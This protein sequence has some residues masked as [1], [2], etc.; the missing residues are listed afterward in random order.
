MK[1]FSF[2]ILTLFL[3]AVNETA[4]QIPSITS[5][6]PAIAKAGTTVL[7]SGSG[8]S[9]NAQQNTV[10]FGP[11]RAEVTGSTATTIHVT[12]PYGCA[13]AFITVTV[14]A[15][16]AR[17]R[18]PFTLAF[19]GSD[20]FAFGSFAQRVEL[21]APGWLRQGTVADLD[22]DGRPDL[23]EPSNNNVVSVYRNISSPGSL[24][25]ASFAARLDFPVGTRPYN[26][27]RG[28]LDGDGK[29]DIICTNNS[30]ANITILRNIS[31]QGSVAFAR[32]DFPAMPTPQCAAVG[33]LD[34]DGK[35]D[36]A[37]TGSGQPGVLVLRNESTPGSVSLTTGIG[38]NTTI[39]CTGVAIADIDGDLK[40]DLVVARGCGVGE[41]SFLTV[42]R[43]TSTP[44]SFQFASGADFPCAIRPRPVAVADLDGDHK[45][46]V[47]FTAGTDAAA[48]VK[49]VSLFRNSSTI[50]SISFAT[51][52]DLDAG[53]SPWDADVGDLNGDGKVDVA[54]P[55]AESSAVAVFQNLSS[56]GSLSFRPRVT[57]PTRV[58]PSSAN[59][60]DLDLDGK[61]DLVCASFG[62]SGVSALR[63][64]LGS[65]PAVLPWRYINTGSSH[66][67]IIPPDANPTVNG[68][69]LSAGDYIG[70][71]Y[72]SSGTLTCAGYERWTG[73]GT[74]AV[75]AFGNDG[76]TP[77]KDGFLAGETFN[78]RI[79][80][81]S[82]ARVYDAEA[83][84]APVGGLITHT[85]A[86][87]TDGISQLESLEAIPAQ[88]RE[89]RSGWS[90]IASYFKPREPSLDTIFNSIR[91]HV[92][93]V[94]NGAQKAFIPSLSLNA[95]GNW[96]ETE[97]YQIKM[98]APRTLCLTGDKIVPAALT[99]PLPAGWSIMPFVRDTQIPVATAL[100]SVVSDV[101]ILKD[102]DGK[103][104]IPSLGVH[105]IDTLRVGE[106]Y[107]IKMAAARTIEFPSNVVNLAMAHGRTA[108]KNEAMNI[109]GPTW[110]FTNTGSSHTV[111][112]PANVVPTV[113]G[114]PLT[115]GDCIGVF[116]D[117]AGVP[118]CAG[119][120]VWP[121]T[122]PIALAAFGDDPTTTAR[123]GL[124]AG[125]LLGWKIWRQ[126]DN[127]VFAATVTYLSSGSLGG[128]VTDSNIY[129]S[130]GISAVQTIHG[131]ATAVPGEKLP[132]DFTLLQN[133]PNPFNPT[134]TI[135]YVLARDCHVNLTVLTTIGQVV[136]TLKNEEQVAGYY[137]IIFE[138][139]G[140]S[141]GMYLYRIKAGEFV[142]TRRFLLLK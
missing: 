54:V 102:Q 139:N 114:V 16:V 96:V 108:A 99:I 67:V 76:T 36:V 140:F 113:D 60:V 11:V 75:S 66:T 84:Y 100:N 45:L 51:P 27:Q 91:E 134:T 31:S 10:H 52:I 26:L 17:S 24:S 116:Y 97:G 128:I 43:N 124:A 88:C 135:A 79:Y 1:K 69:A 9:L 18:E 115:A 73:S 107:Q 86:Y 2:V 85:N 40:P 127:H 28:D 138:A 118:A 20:D 7:I 142:Q 32:Q 74:I 42:F 136:A 30:S 55:M 130:N 25:P 77:E 82:E 90:L 57:F 132:R 5:F 104:F 63:N 22:G 58:D 21:T 41:P 129:N 38:L 87:A 37:V 141:S 64:T 12:V 48:P 68:I 106:A 65:A 117:S 29:L 53:A 105:G 23:V 35:Q 14:N 94:K 3:L 125:E 47:V 8:F 89:L 61:P 71:F 109:G 62:T 98:S 131:S 34:G 95:I 4:A 19:G 119:F 122:G 13:S 83:T 81:S 92:V 78:W 120:E 56:P 33:D 72:D 137:E 59:I 112:I 101:I 121:G 123:D 50:G 49:L 39:G 126:G 93:I 133:Y 111:V 70:V 6:T 103:T 15:L 46:D 80:D 110:Y 44:G